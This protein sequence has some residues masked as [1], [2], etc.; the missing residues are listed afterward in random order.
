LQ[1]P[2]SL[3]SS[4]NRKNRHFDRSCSQSHREQRSGEIRFFLPNRIPALPCL[5]PGGPHL[6]APSQSGLPH[7]RDGL[8][9]DKVGLRTTREPFFLSSKQSQIIFPRFLPKNRMSSPETT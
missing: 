6:N 2:L 8:I 7:L 1:L 3:L 9:V 4:P 5:W